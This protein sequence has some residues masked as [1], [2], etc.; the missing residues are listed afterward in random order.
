MQLG[1]M[2]A[3][4]QADYS[5]PVAVDSLKRVFALLDSSLMAAVNNYMDSARNSYASTYFFE[6]SF[7]G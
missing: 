5:D 7:D 2:M 6:R 1:K 4:S 3:A